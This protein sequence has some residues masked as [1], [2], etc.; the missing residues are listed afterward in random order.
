MGHKEIVKYLLQDTPKNYR[1][2]K[3]DLNQTALH[4]ACKNGYR[5]VVKLL[6]QGTNSGY[7][8]IIDDKGATALTYSLIFACNHNLRGTDIVLMLLK[9]ASVRLKTS[10][11]WK[12]DCFWLERTSIHAAVQTK[13]P[14]IL[15]IMLEGVPHSFREKQDR[16]GDTALHFAAQAGCDEMCGILLKDARPS[17][18]YIRNMRGWT[19]LHKAAERGYTS[20]IDELLNNADLR[21]CRIKSAAGKMAYDIAKYYGKFMAQKQLLTA[22]YVLDMEDLRA[23][24]LFYIGYNEEKASNRTESTECNDNESDFHIW[25]KDVVVKDVVTWMMRTE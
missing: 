15:R 6:L 14:W 19:A 24:M 3:N 11:N 22:E 20:I 2:A 8:E 21:F 16:N 7:K 25:A 18:R 13:N 17:F 23:K 4:L 1:E 5:E 9:D 12:E 10:G